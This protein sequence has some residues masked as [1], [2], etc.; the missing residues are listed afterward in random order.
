MIN[1]KELRI[2]NFLTYAKRGIVVVEEIKRSGKVA[3]AIMNPTDGGPTKRLSTEGALDPILLTPQIL[4]KC[5]F[6][7]CDRSE[8]KDVTAVPGSGWWEIDILAH[9]LLIAPLS[10]G[11]NLM[12]IYDEGD[13]CVL[14]RKFIGFQFV[15]QLQNLY[16]SLTG[17]ELEVKL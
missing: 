3:F 6:V 17:E 4:K 13:N 2:G 1:V 11:H 14:W 10:L 15:H 7:E 8:Y 16:F 9:R 12:C 5:R